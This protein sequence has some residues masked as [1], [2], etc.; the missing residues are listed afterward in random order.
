M[1]YFNDIQHFIENKPARSIAV[2]LLVLIVA[3]L[4]AHLICKFFVVRVVRKVFFSS[5]KNQVPLDKDVR[6]S[7]NYPILFRSSRSTS[8]CSLCR[9]CPSTC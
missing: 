7:E 3:G 5:H 9:T 4:V 8:C 6:L 1:N 2:N